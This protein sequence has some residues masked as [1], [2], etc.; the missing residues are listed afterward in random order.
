MEIDF[1]FLLIYGRNLH[2]S[3]KPELYIYIMV[4]LAISSLVACGELGILRTSLPRCQDVASGHSELAFS[5]QVLQRR[6]SLH[7]QLT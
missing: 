7:C 4:T 6:N 2:E 1:F 5:V 3:D